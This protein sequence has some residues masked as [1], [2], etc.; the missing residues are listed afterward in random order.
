MYTVSQKNKPTLKRYS[1]KLLGLILQTFGRN[2][3]E[4]LE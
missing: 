4:T 1:S 3:Q 2:I